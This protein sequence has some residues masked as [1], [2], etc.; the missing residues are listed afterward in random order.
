MKATDSLTL[1]QNG[2][3]FR[4]LLNEALPS[5][6]DESWHLARHTMLRQDMLLWQGSAPIK[7]TDLA[8]S[9][10]RHATGLAQVHHKNL[11]PVIA[12][13]L[14]EAGVPW[15]AQDIPP[16]RQ[17]SP[18]PMTARQAARLLIPVALGLA[19]LH[20][21]G[22]YHGNVTPSA[23][24]LKP[25]GTPLLGGWKLLARHRDNLA[26]TQANDA[27]CLLDLVAALAAQDAAFPK[28]DA[29]ERI[30]ALELAEFFEDW[31][32][33]QGETD[34]VA[35]KGNSQFLKELTRALRRQE[36]L[37]ALASSIMAIRNA[38]EA[39]SLDELADTILMDPGLTNKLLRTVN[40]VA[41]SQFGSHITTISRAIVILGFD[42]VKS[43]ASTLTI[44]DAI[45]H[46]LKP[47]MRPLRELLAQSVHS[48]LMALEFGLAKF[49][50]S[51]AEEARV[52][53]LLQ[54]LGELM[55]A[56]H[57]PD[58]Y[59]TI[60]VHRTT[61]GQSAEQAALEV[62]GNTF[63]A[64]GRHAL[65]V[66]GAPP[67]LEELAQAV[68]ESGMKGD[69]SGL[70]GQARLCA[71]AGRCLAQAMV[72]GTLPQEVE[73]L[74]ALLP[75]SDSHAAAE[76]LNKVV[77]DA[78]V[79][80]EDE[81]EDLGLPLSYTE[82]AAA[83]YHES[84]LS[85]DSEAALMSSVSADRNAQDPEAVLAEGL[86]EIAN[87]AT[88]GE[89]SA[90]VLDI[91]LEMLYRSGLFDNVVAY[92]AG[93]N[94]FTL[95]SGFGVRARKATQ[96]VLTPLPKQG[97][98]FSLCLARKVDVLIGDATAQN[99]RSR[100]PLDYDPAASFLLMPLDSGTGLLYMDS[101]RKLA[102][103]P[104]LLNLIK[105][106]RSAVCPLC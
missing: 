24:Y 104:K 55:V 93:Q 32:A 35:A 40:A 22:E 77:Q 95:L 81:A 27:R 96:T 42:T 89:D 106:V 69:C 103:S 52:S 12:G 71:T 87:A 1:W 90:T 28:D 94:A 26:A 64:V 58:K 59:A 79:R 39:E 34:L 67:V 48:S 47:D 36:D 84:K 63:A 8:A 54:S 45:G 21:A 53:A 20:Q 99:I 19:V 43:L 88:A 41:F 9:L 65:H 73:R 92:Q 72:A 76:L 13:G 10:V 5:D 15:V 56:F 50:P 33:Q 30:T 82:S 16:N 78:S 85:V 31:L 37:P 46:N 38:A 62:L 91:G 105:A 4:A 11:L 18:A 25:D 29:M 98:V 44:L 75:G 3:P 51:V 60:K 7:D 101:S 100:L 86:R 17:L 14:T 23:I 68:P 2:K 80:F 83:A 66:W 97:D 74:A 61:H 102:L 70:A 57:F 6:N 49:G